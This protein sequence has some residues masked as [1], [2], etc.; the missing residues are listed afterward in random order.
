MVLPAKIIKAL[1]IDPLN[2]FLL[3]KVKG[4]DDLQIQIIREEG[5]TRKKIEDMATTNKFSGPSAM[6]EPILKG[7]VGMGGESNIG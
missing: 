1:D 6:M 2:I 4:M 5:L 7:D 3:L